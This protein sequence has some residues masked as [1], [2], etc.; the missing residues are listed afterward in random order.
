MARRQG[1]HGTPCDT[2]LNDCC[3]VSCL[4]IAQSATRQ[5]PWA[6]R[7]AWALSHGHGTAWL[8]AVP[9]GRAVAGGAGV[10]EGEKEGGGG[11]PWH[12]K[13]AHLTWEGRRC[14]G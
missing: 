2:P 5:T 4:S 6:C 3:R 12:I 11:A 10:G 1:T 8:P 14:T 9:H 13:R 7:A